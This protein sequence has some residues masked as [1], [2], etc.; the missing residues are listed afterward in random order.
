[1]V[2]SILHLV[3]AYLQ[4]ALGDGPLPELVSGSTRSSGH[5]RGLQSHDTRLDRLVAIKVS[6]TGFSERLDHEARAIAALKHSHIRALTTH[7]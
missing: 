2:R 1:V 6:S 3:L 5:G 7:P 4:E